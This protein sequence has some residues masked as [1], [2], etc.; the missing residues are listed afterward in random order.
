MAGHCL[1]YKSLQTRHAQN[2]VPGSMSRASTA[3][4]STAGRALRLALCLLALVLL[5]SPGL[6]RERVDILHCRANAVVNHAVTLEKCLPL[7]RV[8]HTHDVELVAAAVREVL[9]R[10][11]LH[12]GDGGA[13]ERLHRLCVLTAHVWFVPSGLASS[14]LARREAPSRLCSRAQQ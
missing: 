4:W 11:V 7:E 5:D 1:V 2:A 3:T 8:G 12:V 10:E 9:H 14:S 13:H 6:E